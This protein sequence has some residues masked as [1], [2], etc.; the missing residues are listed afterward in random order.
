V[1]E[2]ANDIQLLKTL[3]LC[4]YG[5]KLMIF[6]DKGKPAQRHEWDIE[7]EVNICLE[8]PPMMPN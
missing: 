8:R 3:S 7:K 5:E 6:L 4:I 2:V 1:R